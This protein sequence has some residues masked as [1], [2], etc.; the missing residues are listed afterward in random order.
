MPRGFTFQDAQL[1]VPLA[2]DRAAPQART[3]HYLTALGRLRPHATRADATRDIDA[4]VR[5][6]LVDETDAYPANMGFSMVVEPLT[7]TIVGAVRPALLILLGAVGLLL[8]VA[9]ANV[10]NLLLVRAEGRRRELALRSALGAGRGRLIR[11]LLT[12]SMLLSLVGG[13][14]GLALAAVGV[15]ALLALDSTGLPRQDGVSID[16]TVCAVTVALSMLT[17]IAFGL[18]PALQTLGEDLQAGLKDGITGRSGRKRGLLRRAFV[19]VEVSLAVVL[20]A[21]AALLI[22]TFMRLR[23]VDVGFRPDHI[24]TL[25]LSLPETQYAD[26]M[27]VVAFYDELM[28]DLAALPGVTAAGAGSILPLSGGH[29]NWDVEVEGRPTRPGDP[30]PSPGINIATPGYY[31]AMRIP[32]ARGRVLAESDDVRSMPVAVINETMARS[33]WKGEEALGRRFRILGDSLPVWITVVGITRDVRTW[34]IAGEVRAEYTLAHRQMPAIVGPGRRG[35]S[36][37]LRTSGNPLDLAGPVRREIAALD[38]DLAIS[39]LRTMDRVVSD[40]LSRPRFTMLLL[41]LFGITALVLAAVG[42]YGVMA[43]GV[44]QRAREIGIR[45]ALGAEPRRLRGQIVGEGLAMAVVGLGIGIALALA[46]GRLLASQ[47]YGVDPTD[48][49]TYLAISLLLLGVAFLA[50]WQP[51][52]RATRVDPLGALRAE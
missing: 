5:R 14:L 27:K 35:M 42:V 40:S 50:T 34:G 46:G 31:A 12:E 17:G 44:A 7:D 25:D 16:A 36:V 3:S 32:L 2:I 1:F 11:Q 20:V 39:N 47:L 30:A 29:G 9:C 23:N 43:H 6:L 19:V 15:P 10:A 37:V 38:P 18:A 26:S 51:A 22:Q 48:P 13:A 52:R 45:L 21:G 4:L 41:V 24:L 49:P 33:L 28:R 8:V